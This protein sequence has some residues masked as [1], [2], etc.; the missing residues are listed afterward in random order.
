MTEP[1]PTPTEFL[2]LQDL[3]AL[4]RRL[5]VGPVR[6]LGLLEAACSRPQASLMGVDAYPTLAGKAAA[7]THSVVTSH[8]LVDGN[9]RLGLLALVV[10]LG[11]NDMVLNLSDDEAFHFIM[12]IASGQYDVIEIETT[13]AECTAPF[14]FH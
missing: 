13:L 6:D 3:L 8:A 2:D 5:D 14:E 9:K 12:E 10:F 7:L 4:T 1:E 11:I